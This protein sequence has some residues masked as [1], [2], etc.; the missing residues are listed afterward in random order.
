M[1]RYI[2][3]FIILLAGFKGITSANDDVI[4]K[5]LEDEMNRSMNSLQYE[6]YEKPFYIRYILNRNTISNISASLGSLVVSERRSYNGSGVRLMIGD[7]QLNDEKYNDKVN[8]VYYNDGYAPLPNDLNYWGIRRTFWISTNN[9]YK[10][11]SEKY[12]N[13]TDIMAQNNMT[14]D[15][16]PCAD[17]SKEKTNIS[18]LD[19]LPEERSHEELEQ[20]AKDISAIFLSEKEIIESSTSIEYQ[21]V[22]R[23]FLNS[24]GTKTKI[25]FRFY[26]ILVKASTFTRE[27]R[28]I[29][30]E[31]A[32]NVTSIDDLPDI[33]LM[34]EDA[35][36]LAKNLIETAQADEYK[37]VYNGPVLFL[38]KAVSDIHLRQLL[39]KNKGLIS[40]PRPLVYDKK[41]GLYISDKESWEDMKGKKVVDKKLTITSV[42]FTSDFSD[43]K[44]IGQ[45]FEIDLEG[46][47]KRDT[48]LLVSSGKL[49]NQLNNRTPSPSQQNSLGHMN[50]YVRKTSASYKPGPDVIDFTASETLSQ[51]KIERRLREIAEEEDLEYVFIIAPLE[52]R[53]DKSPINYYKI[54]FET[55]EE[56]LVRA[57][58]IPNTRQ[59]RDVEAFSD[60]KTVQNT[61]IADEAEIKNRMSRYANYP[62]EILARIR[63]DYGTQGTPAS[64]IFPDAMLLKNVEIK[65][66]PTSLKVKKRVVSNPLAI[67]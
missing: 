6:D 2:T 31:L 55:G 11:A 12:K 51:M 29:N 56:G 19:E 54:N 45:S 63:Q 32:Y 61:L 23:Y 57:S 7:Y 21:N 13:K 1:K 48:T 17:F 67:N 52:T 5:A 66:S 39:Q 59:L 26:H 8:R 9:V 64:M 28:I 33:K 30:Q 42:P 25:P 38:N 4:F 18:I 65:G 24:E 40:S 58:F 22:T 35:Q 3:A 10:T 53:A 46:V 43:K 50:Y 15:E 20:L 14:K 37:G 60:R 62:P 44:L 16:M 41:R 27:N 47:V 34:Q 36:A 49:I